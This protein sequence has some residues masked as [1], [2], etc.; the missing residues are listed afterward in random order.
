MKRISGFW[1]VLIIAFLSLH[2]SAQTGHNRVTDSLKNALRA[3]KTDTNKVNLLITLFSKTDLSQS[4]E[5]LQYIIRARD[6]ADTLNWPLGLMRANT[7]MGDYYNMS[8]DYPDAVICFNKYLATAKKIG[9][10]ANEAKALIGLGVTYQYTSEYAKAIDFFQ[11]GL[12]LN[13]DLA[14]QIGAFGNMGTAYSSLGDYPRALKCFET[15]YKML[16]QRMNASKQKDQRD[17]IA[18]IGLLKTIADIYLSMSDY[19]EAL[20]N[21]DS[22]LQMNR[23]LNFPILNL[24]ANTGKGKIFSL[25]KKYLLAIQY[26]QTALAIAEHIGDSSGKAGILN[27]MGNLYLERNI[28]DTAMSYAVRALSLV[29]DRDKATDLEQAPAVYTLLG[30]IF[31]QEKDFTKAR[32]YLKKAVTICQRTG[33]IDIEKDAW[34]ALSNVYTAMNE[35][36]KALDAYKQHIALR[37]SIYSLQ[38]ARE[39]TRIAMQGD[40]DRKQLADSLLQAQKDIKT[41]RRMQQQRLTIYGSLGGLALVLLLSFFTYRN[42]SMQKK[43]NLVIQTE[44]EKAEEQRLRAERSEQFKQQFLANMS[45]EIRTPMN[46]VSGMTDLLLDKDPRPDQENY[47]QVISR[48]SD[49]LLHIINDILDLSKIEAGKLE[50]EHIDFSLADTIRQVKETLSIKAEEKGLQ[51]LSHIDEK[52]P[53]VLVG[54]PYRLNQ[55][56]INLG[57]NAIKFTETGSVNIDVNT[58]ETNNENVTLKFSVEDTGPGI[59]EEKLQRLFESFNQVHSS[60]T[61]KYGGTGLGLSISK[62]LV[63]LQNGNI[64]VDSKEGYGTTFSFTISYPLG[65]EQRLNE[66]VHKEQKADGSV[67]AGLSILLADDNEYNRMVA[68]EALQLKADVTIDEALNGEEAISMLEQKHYDVILM[69]VQMPVMN[70]LDATRHIRNKLP[71][72]KSNTPIIALT[73]SML[74]TDLDKCKEAGMNSYV[75]KPFKTWQL[76]TAIATQTGRTTRITGRT[77]E[78]N[79][80]PETTMQDLRG[81]L[82]DLN[83]LNKFCEGEEERMKKY[84]AIYL[85]A[86][87][88]FEK[89]MNA[90][91]VANDKETIATLVHSFKPKWM[92]MGMKHANELGQR[93]EQLCKEAGNEIQL[94]EQL[95]VLLQQNRGSVAELERIA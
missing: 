88:Q 74:R 80:T 53:P 69:D 14:T 56:L 22:M 6:L 52:T 81:A 86:I 75:P 2:T 32:D 61:R 94:K 92:M 71:V 20:S 59:P 68:R 43:A 85:K 44:K 84:I 70:G 93:I 30:K 23:Q 73:A 78:K 77:E 4:D 18:E 95:S 41:G 51:L 60:D 15:S 38:K 7:L 65:S 31:T 19:D 57:G 8:A 45:H 10:T 49:I 9:D 28:T 83:Y 47:L 16:A 90:A 89:N 27:E 66:R 48:S 76:I 24:M 82:T 37:D 25:E 26:Y 36:A 72:P 12:N 63:E 33:T 1:A 91:I 34:L 40:F 54:D 62:Q 64:S 21:Y 67:L 3:S 35:P 29:E 58:T 13:P 87:P 11:Q 79:E 55:V 39:V 50:L 5:K 42:Y 17:I 46:A